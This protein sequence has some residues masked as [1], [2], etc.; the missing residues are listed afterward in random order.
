MHI[1]STSLLF[2][3]P[4]F[5]RGQHEALAVLSTLPFFV[6]ISIRKIVPIILT[7]EL[8]LLHLLQV[9]LCFPSSSRIQCT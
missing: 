8:R 3:F 6:H 5:R 9:E 1:R 4:L 2:F 7:R